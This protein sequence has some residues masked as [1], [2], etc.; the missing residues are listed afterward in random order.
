MK[1]AMIPVGLV[2]DY[3]MLVGQT[4]RQT[5]FLLLSSSNSLQAVFGPV[6]HPPQGGAWLFN[7]VEK[8]NE[9]VECDVYCQ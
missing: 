2:C 9:N 6:H 1:G 3:Y 7:D 5:F 4:D 8:K